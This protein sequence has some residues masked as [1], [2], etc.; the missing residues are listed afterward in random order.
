MPVGHL[1]YVRRGEEQRGPYPVALIE[2]NI[3]LGRILAEDLLSA[4]G[5]QWHPAREFPDFDLYRQAG[6]QETHRRLDERQAERR[7]LSEKS[8]DGPDNRLRTDRRQAEDPL[9]VQRREHS[10]RV[11]QGLASGGVHPRHL[12]LAVG[13]VAVG[14]F[15]LGWWLRWPQSK[16]SVQC[17]AAATPAIVWDFCD[18]QGLNLTGARLQGAHLRNVNFRGANLTSANLTTANLAYTNL[19]EARL[20]AARLGAA[21]LTGATLHGADLTQ[22]N[23]TGANLSFADLSGAKLGGATL[24]GAN[25]SNTIWTDGQLCEAASR[26]TCASAGA[27]RPDK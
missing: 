11:W 1:W 16:P 6:A 14:V 8:I 20:V 17:E 19:S 22:A 26:G 9:E 5:E 2:R 24:S 21:D 18:K 23:L 3:G 7:R 27:A 4:D 12:Y 10:N 13:L 25:L 15:L